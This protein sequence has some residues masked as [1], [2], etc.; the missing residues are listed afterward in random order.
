MSNSPKNTKSFERQEA[1]RAWW[2]RI[3]SG[4]EVKNREFLFDKGSIARLRRAS[5]PFDVLDEPVVFEL[6]RKLCF[7]HEQAAY[8]LVPVAV[9]ACVI[10]RVSADQPER[11]LETILGSPRS[12][13]GQV[14]DRAGK[15]KNKAGDKPKPL[16]SGTRLKRLMAARDPE[17]L[18]R[19]MRRAIDL[20][21]KSTAVDVGALAVTILDWL[22]PERCDRTRAMFAYE[23]HA[24]G[25]RRPGLPA[26]PAS[27]PAA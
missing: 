13:S 10:A 26:E 8:R 6:Y 15:D 17:D 2:D 22:H 7:K 12:K 21:G 4:G 14:E 20:L 19:Q 9:V 25:Y 24:A 3:P 18:L 16:L 5:S 11:R 27:P 23:Y 1:A